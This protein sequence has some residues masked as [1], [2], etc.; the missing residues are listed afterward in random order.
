MF[1][2]YLFINKQQMYELAQISDLNLMG[3]IS[4]KFDS[5]LPSYCGFKLLHNPL[6]HHCI[7]KDVETILF[8]VTD[9]CRW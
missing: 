7:S 9:L 1:Y 3:E 8:T 4:D 6:R 5:A 2:S